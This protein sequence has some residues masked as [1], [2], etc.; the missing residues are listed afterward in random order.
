M[1]SIQ[2][3]TKFL[4][5]NG[6]LALSGSEAAVHGMDKASPLEM[7]AKQTVMQQAM[8]LSADQMEEGLVWHNAH[9]IALALDTL[10]EER[11][12]ELDSLVKHEREWP[13]IPHVAH[14][15]KHWAAG[16]N[17]PANGTVVSLGTHGGRRTGRYVMPR[18]WN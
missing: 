8:N 12:K 13:H 10:I 6:L 15:L 7:V 4:S 5:P 17:R 3:A 11:T 9:I 2:L 14:M 1:L 16:E 18:Y